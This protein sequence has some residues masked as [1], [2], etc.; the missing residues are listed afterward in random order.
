[1]QSITKA[2]FAMDF[3][4]N[5][6]DFVLCVLFVMAIVFLPSKLVSSPHQVRVKLQ[7]ETVNIFTSYT[8][9]TFTELGLF[10]RKSRLL[11]AIWMISS[12]KLIR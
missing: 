10:L 1:M 3:L 2:E 12:K 7:Q 8:V 9:R 4:M 11:N 6:A 5:M